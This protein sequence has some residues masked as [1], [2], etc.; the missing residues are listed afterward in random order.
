M[1]LVAVRA[2]KRRFPVFDGE[3]AR[4]LGGRWNSPGRPLVYASSCLAGA[5]L[6]ILVQA[7]RMSLP[8]PY[9]CAVAEIPDDVPH[10]VLEPEALP[11]WDSMPDSLAARLYGDRWLAEARTAVLVV[12]AATA[13]P[14]QR[15]V[16]LN[17][18]H[19]AY[20]RIALRPPTPVAWDVRLIAGGN[21]AR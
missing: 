11:G 14:L 16:L 7:N 9:H 1:A 8:G 10:E 5:L 21:A 19:P 4:L 3:G 12:P 20:S 6:E 18:R 2:A 13:R 15:H 17:P